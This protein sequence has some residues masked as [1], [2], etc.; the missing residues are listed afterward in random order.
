MIKL[1]PLS[2]T[3]KPRKVAKKKKI[4]FSPPKGLFLVVF[5]ILVLIGVSFV[6]GEFFK[7]TDFSNCNSFVQTAISKTC[8]LGKG[9]FEKLSRA[10]NNLGEP[11]HLIPEVIDVSVDSDGNGLIVLGKN[12]KIVEIYARTANAERFWGEASVSDLKGSSEAWRF[13]FPKEPILVEEIIVKAEPKDEREKAITFSLPLTGSVAIYQLIWGGDG[14]DVFGVDLGLRQKLY[15]GQTAILNAGEVGI[16]FKEV[17]SDSRCP[18]GVYCIWQGKV[19]AN[20]NLYFSNQ[21]PA[22]VILSLDPQNPESAFFD[23][24]KDLRI[25]LV[26]VGPEVSSKKINLE[27][28]DYYVVISVEKK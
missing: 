3:K 13:E 8:S 27:T 9:F 14:A 25:R 19:S 20:L 24:T 22:E 16:N 2:R 4:R 1:D 6:S 23:A 21:L 10:A 26:S 12:L 5:S 17:V 7:G 11:P 15:S 28:E 18:I